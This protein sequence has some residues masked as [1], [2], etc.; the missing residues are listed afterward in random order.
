MYVGGEK[1]WGGGCLINSIVHKT[2]A[3]LT[4]DFCMILADFENSPT[5]GERLQLPTTSPSLMCGMVDET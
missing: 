3:R 1:V 2:F 5:V 4:A